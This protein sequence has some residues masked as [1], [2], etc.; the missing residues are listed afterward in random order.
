[1]GLKKVPGRADKGREVIGII[2]KRAYH[3]VGGS[4]FFLNLYF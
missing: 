4:K 1:M 3:M 2:V